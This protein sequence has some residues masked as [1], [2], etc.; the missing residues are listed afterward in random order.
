MRHAEPQIVRLP[1]TSLRASASL[2][3]E[4]PIRFGSE[5]SRLRGR[6]WKLYL[7]ALLLSGK[8]LI[9]FPGA[10]RERDEQ[11]TDGPK[12]S[13]SDRDL[14]VMTSRYMYCLAN[15]ASLARGR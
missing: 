11:A 10:R 5:P 4:S 8:Q 6:F 3:G 13:S 9:D 12:H 15:P 1:E 7:N 2:L 14:G